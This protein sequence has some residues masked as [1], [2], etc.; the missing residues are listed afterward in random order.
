[1][2]HVI[3]TNNPKTA[4]LY[5]HWEDQIV[6]NVVVAG[7]G[8]VSFSLFFVNLQTLHQSFHVKQSISASKAAR[9]HERTRMF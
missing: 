6:A 1:M 4:I 3:A 2:L 8:N 7:G 5:T 9:L